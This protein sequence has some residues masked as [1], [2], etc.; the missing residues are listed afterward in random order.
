MRTEKVKSSVL[1]TL[2]LFNIDFENIWN[3]LSHIFATNISWYLFANRHSIEL[4]LLKND[5]SEEFITGDQPVIN[6]HTASLGFLAPPEELEFYYPVSP[7]L[8]ILITEEKHNGDENI[9]FLSRV[10]VEEYN[11]MIAEQSHTQIYARSKNYLMKY[12]AK[13]R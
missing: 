1:E 10:E 6:T 7:K 12:S 8:A 3:V 5:T 9:K 11:E 2:R 13:N 4:V